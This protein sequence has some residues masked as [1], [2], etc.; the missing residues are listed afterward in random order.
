MD[1]I[2]KIL[3]VDDDPVTCKTLSTVLEREG[4]NVDA[5]L[6]GRDGLKRMKAKPADIVLLDLKLPDAEGIELLPKLKKIKGEFEVIMITGF[7]SLDTAVEAIRLGAAGY[8]IKPVMMS[9]FL[10]LINT[11]A[12][13]QRLAL[14]KR[15]D[16]G[17]IR[18]L[19]SVLKA[20]RMASRLLLRAE[21]PDALVRGICDTLIQTDGFGSSWIILNTPGG[22]LM[23]SA[24]AGM[25]SCFVPVIK[26]FKSKEKT[27][28]FQLA[29]EAE[30]P[31]LLENQ[32][33]KYNT[34]QLPEKLK[35]H[36][37]LIIKLAF[38]DKNYGFLSVSL[39]S[40][41]IRD[42]RIL[43]LVEDVARDTAFAIDRIY[44]QK[45]DG[46]S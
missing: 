38:R 8:M 4:F 15:A 16:E 43:D 36:Q 9:Q 33:A 14:E 37:V 20:T 26:Q 35:N 21:D 44:Q 17:K 2:T 5:A 10:T 24:S 23:T 30:G 13:K 41:I 25:G 28:C 7:A 19:I 42:K 12:E 22:K 46:L 40:V 3:I 29:M 31:V 6:S 1:A 34:C 32:P 11:L 18:L 39:P 45:T 27:G